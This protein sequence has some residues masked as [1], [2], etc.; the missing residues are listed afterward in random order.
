MKLGVIYTKFYPLSSSA[1]VHGYHLFKNLREE[2]VEL[3]TIGIG[4]NT[5][6]IDHPKN[7]RGLISF[8]RSIDVIYIR[9][10]PWLWND[11]F[12]LVKLLS[13][14]RVKVVWEINA[15]VEEVFAAY[16]QGVPARI[17][18]WFNRQQFKRKLLARFCDGSISVSRILENYS[19][20]VLKIQNAISIPNAADPT[21]FKRKE[22]TPQNPLYNIVKNKFVI[23]WAGNGAIGWQ[24]TNML[25][26]LAKYYAEKDTDIFFLVMSNRSTYNQAILPNLLSLAEISHDKLPEFLQASHVGFCL[27]NSYDWCKYGFYGSSLKQFDYLSMEL[28]VLANDMGQLSEIITD[29]E[30]G[31]LVENDLHQLIQKIDYCKREYAQLGHIRSNARKLITEHYNWKKVAETTADFIQKLV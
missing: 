18:R 19:K 26:E 9:I 29:G 22:L 15:P 20:Q 27:Y 28:L 8:I 24:G 7:I 25:V 13:F 10:N 16:Q 1:S 17:K 11:W 12:T 31:F 3:H 14:G 5:L 30:S 2:G 21:L 6:T 4:Q 23:S